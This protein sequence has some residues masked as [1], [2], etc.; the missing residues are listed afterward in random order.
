[1]QHWHILVCE[2]DG[3]WIINGSDNGLSVGRQAIIWANG[4]ILSIRPGGTYF[5]EVLFQMKQFSLMKMHLK[6]TYAKMSAI[7]SEP[8][9]LGGSVCYWPSLGGCFSDDQR[10]M[11][12]GDVYHL[13]FVVLATRGFNQPPLFA[14]GSVELDCFTVPKLLVAVTAWFYWLL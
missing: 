2:L 6:M 9:C 12:P 14:C 13:V 3:V 8:Q 11:G 1:M 5:S 7:L 4:D 10:V